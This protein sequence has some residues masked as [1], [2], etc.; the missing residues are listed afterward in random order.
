MRIYF[1]TNTEISIKN[2]INANFIKYQ[3]FSLMLLMRLLNLRL[4][5]DM[6]KK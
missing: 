6:N 2:F 4:I 1:L 3:K 5:N